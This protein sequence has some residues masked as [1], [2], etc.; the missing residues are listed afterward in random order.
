MVD[1]ARN[2][3]VIFITTE[4]LIELNSSIEDMAEAVLSRMSPNV[5]RVPIQEENFGKASKLGDFT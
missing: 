5:F 4:A 1:V 3:H 2:S